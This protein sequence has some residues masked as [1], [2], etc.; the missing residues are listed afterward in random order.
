MK[1]PFSF[2]LGL[3]VVPL[4]LL[5]VSVVF[6]GSVA[7][8]H[9]FTAGTPVVAADMNAN[10]EAVRDAIN[11]NDS[12]ILALEGA[13]T[14]RVDQT[15]GDPE[16]SG[17]ALR[18]A[19][20]AAA[21]GTLIV[22]GPGRYDT[23]ATILRIG[24]GVHL[25]GAGRDVTSITSSTALTVIGTTGPATISGCTLEST[26]ATRSIV[27]GRGTLTLLFCRVRI[28][29]SAGGTLAVGG[30][31]FRA[32]HTDFVGRGHTDVLEGIEVVG[33]ADGRAELLDCRIDIDGEGTGVG[34]SCARNDSTASL[35]SC[36]IR[37]VSTAGSS[38]GVSAVTGD[39][40]VLLH[41]CQ[42]EASTALNVQ[43]GTA[44]IHAVHCL[45]DGTISP[46][47]SDAEVRLAGCF[48]AELEPVDNP[49]DD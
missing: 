44:R 42:V 3:V 21:E 38:T 14:I 41:A 49:A 19:V 28:D 29:S 13:N 36:H 9:T 26:N 7:V 46:G 15:P 4:A 48:D 6:A 25:R 8:P 12:R 34:L 16:A 32:E 31:P 37:V 23:G 5:L 1:T 20:A 10:F 18:D 43:S 2:S 17:D 27:L 24:T 47:L 11:D 40:F 39:A 35:V 45:L 30:D 33:P 22:L